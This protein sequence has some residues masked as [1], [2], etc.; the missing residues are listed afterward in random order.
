MTHTSPS[1]N[2]LPAGEEVCPTDTSDTYPARLVVMRLGKTGL[3]DPTKPSDEMLQE[4]EAQTHD[5]RVFELISLELH[6]HAK[7][8][9]ASRITP[10][11]LDGGLN[12]QTIRRIAAIILA[13]NADIEEL[14][15]SLPADE[16]PLLTPD[17]VIGL[18][19][20]VMSH[21]AAQ[22]DSAT[23]AA[24]QRLGDKGDIAWS[25]RY[26]FRGI[27]RRSVEQLREQGLKIVFSG[28]AVAD[29]K[30][31]AGQ[32][33]ANYNPILERLKNRRIAEINGFKGSK[34]SLVI[35]DYMDH[36]W[37]MNLL[38]ENGVMDRHRQLFDAI[39]NPEKTDIFKREG[40][41]IASISFG[42]RMFGNIDS[43]FRPIMDGQQIA[44]VMQSYNEQGVLKPHHQAAL[45]IITTLAP[46][47]Q[48]YQSLGFVFSNYI[49][50]LD[51]Q[52]RKFGKIMAKNLETG[53]IEGELD[54]LGP[55]YLPF[56]I[57]AHHQL[58]SANNHYRDI[59]F[60]VHVY[61]EDQLRRIAG[62]PEDRVADGTQ[63]IIRP[64]LLDEY[65]YSN[66]VINGQAIQWMQD[67]Y[68]F[69]ATKAMTPLVE[70][71]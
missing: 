48:E 29:I 11:D 23:E 22:T 16:Q 19:D 39:G 25:D 33:D 68:G 56:F 66:M 46:D 7:E 71:E 65:D 21:L 57:E 64:D 8:F 36:F 30:A 35:H 60:H 45:D 32:E 9:I 41:A 15:M 62:Q 6:A 50:E 4:L 31:A 37:T 43:N 26:Q 5:A 12:N 51:E 24:E 44:A 38:E 13:E 18:R 28:E 63:F 67:N 20:E 58:L 59:L 55:E 53:E 14:I 42:I 17:K 49:T 40:E 47:D 2:Y 3:V 27:A 54:P 10:D 52:R 69:M 70:E 61:V 1:I 34:I